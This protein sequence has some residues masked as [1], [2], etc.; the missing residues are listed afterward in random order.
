MSVYIV[1]FYEAIDSYLFYINTAFQ[2]YFNNFQ[3]I[4]K[5]LND[6]LLKKQLNVKT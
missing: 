4:Q 1:S 3:T 2:G 5:S 6:C